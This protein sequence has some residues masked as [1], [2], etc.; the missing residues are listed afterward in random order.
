MARVFATLIKN[1]RMTIDEVPQNIRAEVEAILS[2][3]GKAD[4]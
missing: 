4:A 2:E 1:D 3:E